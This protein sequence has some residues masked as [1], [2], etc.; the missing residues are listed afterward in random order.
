M[1]EE[2]IGNTIYFPVEV[3]DRLRELA[4]HN[5]RSINQ[6]VIVCVETICDM[7]PILN[8]ST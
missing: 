6:Q 3:Y 2:R 1:S 4:K 8:K 5:R 7:E